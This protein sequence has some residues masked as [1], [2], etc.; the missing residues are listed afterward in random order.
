VTAA[1][2]VL[3]AIGAHPAARAAERYLEIRETQPT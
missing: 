3:A 2:V 1:I